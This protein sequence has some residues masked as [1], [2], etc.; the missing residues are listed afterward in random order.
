MKSPAIKQAGQL[1]GVW[2]AQRGQDELLLLTYPNKPEGAQM[3]KRM[4]TDRLGKFEIKSGHCGVCHEGRARGFMPI[5]VVQYKDSPKVPDYVAQSKS[6][7]IRN[8]KTKNFIRTIG[9][10]CGCYAKV[11]RQIAHIAVAKS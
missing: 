5:M 10:N 6:L 7:L 9:I 8:K 3:A 4:G 11:H 1:F 2:K